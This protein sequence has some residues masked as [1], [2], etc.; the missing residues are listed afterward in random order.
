MTIQIF[1]IDVEFVS[2]NAGES[3]YDDTTY[4]H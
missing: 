1:L 4:S 3:L 2:L